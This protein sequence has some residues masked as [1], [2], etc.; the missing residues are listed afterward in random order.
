M[1][2]VGGTQIMELELIGRLN[3]I[4]YHFWSLIKNNTQI[5]LNMVVRFI[6]IN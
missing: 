5:D 2:F 1:L 6:Y 4:Q 3:E